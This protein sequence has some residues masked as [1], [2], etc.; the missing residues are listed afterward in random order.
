MYNFKQTRFVSSLCEKN[1]SK[2]ESAGEAFAGPQKANVCAPDSTFFFSALPLPTAF[3]VL[4]AAIVN[5]F[6]NK[7]IF[8]TVC[9]VEAV[10]AS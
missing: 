9:A 4:E 7:F 8:T 5:M 6:F 10:G 2:R 3:A 1:S